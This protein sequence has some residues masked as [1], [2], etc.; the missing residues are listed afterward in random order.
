MDK[1]WFFLFWPVVFALVWHFYSFTAAAIVAFVYLHCMVVFLLVLTD[2]QD[3]K[4]K[5][6]TGS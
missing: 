6:M 3:R 4:I 5:N 1:L 2:E